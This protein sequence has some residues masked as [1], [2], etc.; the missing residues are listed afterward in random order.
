M[1]AHCKKLN[2]SLVNAG[3]MKILVNSSKNLVLLMIKPNVDIEYE[4]FDGCNSK[5]KNDLVDVVNHDDDVFHK[6][7]GFPSK[8][9]VFFLT[10][11]CTR[12]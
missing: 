5:L 10:L 8:R 12:C 9:S 11:T 7:K 4:A 2:L 3:Q 1:R 6:E